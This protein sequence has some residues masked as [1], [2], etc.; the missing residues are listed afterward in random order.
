M[1]ISLFYVTMFLLNAKLCSISALI[2]DVFGSLNLVSLSRFGG[3]LLKKSGLICPVAT[4][5]CRPAEAYNAMCSVRI[6]LG[7]VMHP[8]TSV[9]SVN[10]HY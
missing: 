6:N 5:H 2:F 9:N 7:H 8:N 4:L 1:I 3:F 10:E